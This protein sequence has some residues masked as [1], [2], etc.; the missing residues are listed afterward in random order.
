[1]SAEGLP[2]VLYLITDLGAAGGEAALLSAIDAVLA[3]VGADVAIQLRDK[4]HPPAMRERLGHALR[5][6][7][8]AHGSLLFVNSTDG[9]PDL[10]LAVRA[11]GVHLPD[12]SS[13]TGAWAELRT[14][15]SA[16]DSRGLQRAQEAGACFATLS[17]VRTSPH[18]GPPLGWAGF[19]E[20]CRS[21]P[22]PVVALGGMVAA[23]AGTARRHGAAAVATIR[24]VFAASDPAAAA[25]EFVHA[26]RS[27]VTPSR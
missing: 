1:L 16:H 21:T 3:A 23:D 7:T 22:L 13:S 26:F 18:K 5:S 20:A 19:E 12:G 4:H 2:F 14:A 8:R 24:G 27:G 15:R 25:R 17:P 10:A 6:R 11:D 9:S